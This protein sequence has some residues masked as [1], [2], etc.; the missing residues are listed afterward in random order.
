MPRKAALKSGC[1]QR[2][3]PGT[4]IRHSVSI[5]SGNQLCQI[6]TTR[7]RCNNLWMQLKHFSLSACL[8]TH[9]RCLAEAR[10]QR[11]DAASPSYSPV[12]LPAHDAHT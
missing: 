11:E 2:F 10:Y 5:S 3:S 9:H 7:T 1:W 8:L 4:R 6:Q 12:P